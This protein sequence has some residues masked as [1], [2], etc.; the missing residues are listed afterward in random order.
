MSGQLLREVTGNVMQAGS[1]VGSL[2]AQEIST[3]SITVD[4]VRYVSPGT[5]NV[6]TTVTTAPGQLSELGIAWPG[7]QPTGGQVLSAASSAGDL[8]WSTALTS[9][10]PLLT[11]AQRI[12]VKSN[13]GVGEF[14]S[15]GAAVASIT[16]AAVNKPYIVDVGP[17]V[18]SEGNVVVPSYVHVHGMSRDAVTVI[19]LPGFNTFVLSAEAGVNNLAITG[20]T[21]P[22]CAG[23]LMAASSEKY[24][25]EVSVEDT[26][27]GFLLDA[28]TA[29][30]MH[31][32]ATNLRCA[33]NTTAAVMCRS[34]GTGIAR[35]NIDGF[36][37]DETTTGITPAFGVVDGANA[38]L[39]IFG[40]DIALEV[41]ET[42]FGVGFQVYNG[43]S[44][45]VNSS[46]VVRFVTGMNVPADGGSPLA[47]LNSI[48][49]TEVSTLVDVQNP[50]A[51]G[52][53][54]GEIGDITKI[55][56]IN[57]ALFHISNTDNHI[58][59]VATT[60]GDFATVK[61]AL[62][63]VASQPR[64]ITAPW[65]I[66]VGPGVFS[67]DNPLIVPKYTTINGSGLQF[68]HITAQNN[69]SNL[70]EMAGTQ[71]TI[72][73]LATY[74]PSTASAIYYGGEPF[75][76]DV[77]FYNQLFFL[78]MVAAH[79]AIELDTQNGVN[80]TDIKT[81]ALGVGSANY[82]GTVSR[83]A[84]RMTSSNTSF[85]MQSF[86]TDA[87][88]FAPPGQS[89]T[90]IPPFD[91][92]TGIDLT[93]LAGAPQIEV[94]IAS[95]VVVQLDPPGVARGIVLDHV[96][97]RMG[98]CLMRSLGV[99]L[100]FKPGTLP[101][102]IGLSGYSAYI[103]AKD[104][105]IENNNVTGSILAV[106]ATLANMDDSSAPNHGI[107]FLVQGQ[108]SEGATFTGPV[109]MGHTLS[110]T[111]SM[112]PSFQHSGTTTG[113]LLGGALSLT[114]GLGVQVAAG[115]G[116]VT[117]TSTGNPA[118]VSWDALPGTMSAN[119]DQVLSVT[120]AGAL[121]FTSS[122]PSEYA[123]IVIARLKSDATDVVFV[124]ETGRQALHTPT[125]LDTTMRSAF[126][127]IVASGM[128]GAAGTGA[129]QIDV[130]NG[131]YY[132][133]THAY[134]PSGGSDV[135][136]LPH[137]HVSG[138]WVTGAATNQLS[139]A[140]ARRYDDGTDLVAL[141]GGEWVKHALYAVND[142][143]FE[144]YLFVYGQTAFASQSAA[145]N[146]SLPLSPPFFGGNVA[147]VSALV[148]GD[149]SVD[150]VTVQDIRPTL[151]FTAAGV[152]ATT[153]HGS[154]TGL[155]DDDHTQYLLTSGT[156]S[157]AGALD[158]GS[159][160][161]INTGTID[162][163]TIT[164][165]SD[166][167]RPGGADEIPTGAPVT[168]GTANNIGAAT[169][170]ARSDHIHAHGD[171]TVT[172]LHALVTGGG[173]GF[174]S[175]TDKTKLDASTA[176]STASTLVERDGAGSVSVDGLVVDTNGAIQLANA[177]DTFHVS[178]VAPAALAADYTLTLPPNDGDN[179]QVLQTNGAGVT[180]WVASAAGFA[181][182]MTTAGDIII[183]NAGNSTTRLAAGT[184]TNQVLTTDSTGVPAWQNRGEVADPTA[185]TTVTFTDDFL[186]DPALR[187]TTNPSA[188]VFPYTSVV[189]NELGAV[190]VTTNSGTAGG[191]H[192]NMQGSY[193]RGGIGGLCIKMRVLFLNVSTPATDESEVMF[194]LGDP[195]LS[196][197]ASVDINN[198]V[199]FMIQNNTSVQVRTAAGGVRT[200][201]TSSPLQTVAINTWYSAEIRVTDTAGTWTSVE[202]LWD[203]VSVGTVTTN[204]P[205]AVSQ[206]FA[207]VFYIRK[208]VN[209]S[210][211]AALM[212][213]Y[214]FNYTLTSTR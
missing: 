7:F 8:T 41:G 19:P 29:T 114:G 121:Q 66:R 112:L 107:A 64:S 105:L 3:S 189:S 62:A 67:E 36:T 100:A 57:T 2:E 177:A 123:A 39:T 82:D 204:L 176:A 17:G 115:D 61:D 184:A 103:N 78:D 174:M 46:R 32:V 116:Y 85:F 145:E 187:W 169:T 14:S 133:S 210:E 65:E 1:F 87:R 47:T 50:N 23:V 138:S 155:L 71:I 202:F 48:E 98:A 183:R 173:H 151:A 77:F 21:N 91:A 110:T 95:C 81:I 207:P 170:L 159:N 9:T 163:V 211:H 25:Y 158:L 122:A 126:G 181:D 113:L 152:T 164:D 179:L 40:G 166:R 83:Y 59:S 84:I 80:L 37:F 42:P 160:N 49:F 24:V 150:W 86:I 203:D 28:P 212:D 73:D 130:S 143:A 200:T 149:A 201:Q 148:L 22:G 162:G 147:G 52:Y 26:D 185:S 60:G 16:D 154:L 74:G 38:V 205:N 188:R 175:S 58:L 199:I 106:N 124:H 171:Q 10:D 196:N 129:F 90:G 117:G 18:Y 214:H 194:G 127:A 4:E 56:I 70:F 120:S 20:P 134:A 31:C 45:H 142:G 33:R 192:A 125:L 53:I 88:I 186:F 156:R 168:V 178:L 161:I 55:N 131:S 93:G 165:M 167:L 153:D 119:S 157:M 104:V 146:G 128:I 89:A 44:L 102:E 206:P 209:N 92:F 11:V 180:S 30:T 72:R 6:A 109:N 197:A 139:A 182:P 15:I 34:V 135:S 141:A 101:S 76:A 208:N 198:G 213:Y 172:T 27:I 97:A 13:P 43:G 193:I 75:G 111:T 144:T 99:G 136:F 96:N 69:A 12:R 190:R 118:Y 51:T 132:Y 191:S 137:N 195:P 79:T 94:I 140:N 5:D 68:T 108:L 63:F 54:F 35:F